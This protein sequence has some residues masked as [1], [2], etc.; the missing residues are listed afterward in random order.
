MINNIPKLLFTF[1]MANNHMGKVSHGKKIIRE[2]SDICK[3]FPEF[4]F[5]FKL[6]YRD[7]DSFIH[8]KMKDRDDIKYIKRFSETR[9]TR[10]DF[11]ELVAFIKEH[12]FISMVTPF[13]ENS[14]NVL[15]KQN[16][17]LIKVASCSLMIG[18]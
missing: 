14:V 18:H 6:Q 1:E 4:N 15:E 8:P 17:D 3:N 9:L 10:E 12:D 2:F 13:D 5:A 11:D 16:V 7:L